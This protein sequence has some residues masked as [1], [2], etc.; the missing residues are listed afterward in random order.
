M[1]LK[2]GLLFGGRSAEHEVSL[3]SAKNVLN[4]LVKA[5]H[6]VIP[7][8]IDYEGL[9]HLSD[10]SLTFGKG[11]PFL[12]A[13]RTILP[14][15]DV[16]FPV[17]HGPYGED[18]TFQGFF[19]VLQIPYVGA[20]VLGSAVS[21]D[22]DVMKRLL[23]N[24]GIRVADFLVYTSAPSFREVEDALGLPFFIKPANMGSS[25]GM[26]KVEREE[27]FLEAVEEAFSYDTKIIIE[28]N[29]KGR[30][31]EC[32]VLGGDPVTASLPGELIPKGGI[33]TY[34]MKYIDPDGA[35]FLLP[36]P[37]SIVKTQEVQDLSIHAFK[38]LACEGMAR[39]DFFVTAEEVLYVNEINTIPGFTNMSLYPKLW[40]ISG[41]P[42]EILVDRLITLALEKH[43]RKKSLSVYYDT[44]KRK[45]KALL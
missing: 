2:I 40:E 4:A 34:E 14:S 11:L 22:K 17:L 31:I 30:E 44:K 32:S 26:T 19:E 8:G 1:Q 29:I 45:E 10:S 38:V 37:L 13:A 27:D 7:V 28:E 42:T 25:V 35:K 18:G 33:Y 39:V 15:I 12:E 16:V 6:E 24:E 20:G 36:A 43:A 5:G 3:S 21:M 9:W 23:K 41:M